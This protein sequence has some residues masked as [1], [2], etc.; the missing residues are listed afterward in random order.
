MIEAS[1]T[2]EYLVAVQNTFPE[3]RIPTDDQAR[4]KLVEQI[5]RRSPDPLTA[6][7]QQ[8]GSSLVEVPARLREYLSAHRWELEQ[9]IAQ[10]ATPTPEG[11]DVASIEG[12]LTDRVALL[13]GLVASAPKG[14]A[15]WLVAANPVGSSPTGSES[16][17][18]V[19]DILELG[20]ARGLV[21]LQVTH[22]HALEPAIGPVIRV[23]KGF[24]GNRPANCQAIVEGDTAF[25]TTFAVDEALR[26]GAMTRVAFAP[27]PL[28]ETAFPTFR[29]WMGREDRGRTVWGLWNGG[30]Q[31]VSRLLGPL[32]AEQRSWPLLDTLSLDELVDYIEREQRPEDEED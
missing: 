19:G 4:D 13:A 17:V 32:T 18:R 24:H 26:K 25:R 8:Y 21:Y 20:T 27:L 15:P 23:V 7:D 30:L 6:L 2:A 31:T 11:R 14:D 29:H 16:S 9:Q 22:K 3:N 12:Q 28:R 5:S 1:R 10:G